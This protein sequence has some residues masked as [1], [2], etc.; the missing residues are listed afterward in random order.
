MPIDKQWVCDVLRYNASLIK[1]DLSD[2]VNDV[3]TPSLARICWFHYPNVIFILLMQLIIVDSKLIELVGQDIGV[4][5]KIIDTLSE[6]CLELVYI[7][8]KS[9]FSCYLETTRKV[10]NLL[11]FVQSFI[12]IA[13]ARAGT[14][15]QITSM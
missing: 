5:K 11:I 7:L 2:L 4:G 8:A 13:F 3:D 9:I 1:V 6:P 10:V 15:Q 14:P 12:L